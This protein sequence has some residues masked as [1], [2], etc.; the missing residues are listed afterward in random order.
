MAQLLGAVRHIQPKTLQPFR[1]ARLTCSLLFRALNLIGSILNNFPFS[2]IQFGSVNLV[3]V[4]FRH[5]IPTLRSWVVLSQVFL[6]F[7]G[8][9]LNTWRN[10]SEL[11]TLTKWFVGM[12][13]G[14]FCHF[15]DCFKVNCFV[16]TALYM[17]HKCRRDF[18]WIFVFFSNK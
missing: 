14:L 5:Q 3:T 1:T 12:F 6:N 15:L 9:T 2:P 4:G 7:F 16:R 13:Y 8:A 18:L 17:H 11:P 10:T